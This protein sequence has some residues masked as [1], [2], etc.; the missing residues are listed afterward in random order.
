M[1]HRILIF[2]LLFLFSACDYKIQNEGQFKPIFYKSNYVTWWDVQYGQE[3]TQNMDIYLRGNEYVSRDSHNVR[4]TG[5]QPPTIIFAHG[6]AWYFSDKRKHE[7]YI[8]PFLQKGYNVVNLNY[9]KKEGVAKATKD[10]RKA[11]LYLLRNN[12]RFHLDLNNIVLAGA[13]AGA[14]MST[15]LAVAQ[16]CNEPEKSFTDSLKIIASINIMG[17]GDNCNEIYYNLKNHQNQWWRNVGQSLVT[18]QNK[19][20]SILLAWCPSEYLD[21]NDPP[22]FIT[23]GE[24]DQ[25]LDSSGNTSFPKKLAS[26]NI[27]H[28]VVTYPNSGHGFL[29][30]DYNDMFIRIFNF[31]DKYKK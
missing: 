19:A 11:L 5:K 27:P 8:S 2:I 18:N 6:S 31:I 13:S 4:L 12:N 10:Y 3:E 24:K 1:I 14:Y 29:T 30:E 26:L 28:E 21:E 25:F 23:F 22:I 20:D 17:G 16:N 7:H 15:F 9:A